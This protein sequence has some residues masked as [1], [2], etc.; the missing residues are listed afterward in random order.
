M[1]VQEQLAPYINRVATLYHQNASAKLEINIADGKLQVNLFHELDE[2]KLL[3]PRKH[4]TQSYRDVLK[5]NM[6]TSQINRLKRRAN[7]RAEEAKAAAQQAAN[8]PQAEQ[9]KAGASNPE[10][11][12]QEETEKAL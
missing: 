6:K 3:P 11:E 8:K 1:S 12:S 9:A 10:A 4:P 5:K 2:V 7:M